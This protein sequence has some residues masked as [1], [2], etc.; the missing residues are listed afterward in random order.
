M[1]SER[2]RIADKGWGDLLVAAQLG[3]AGA[4]R[5][6]VASVTPFVSAVARQRCWSADMVP[7]VVQ[8]VMLSVHRVRHTYET[9][10]PVKP[11]L[12]AIAVR[13][14]IDAM[15]RR[16]HLQ[17]HEV[18]NQA[19]YDRYADPRH[20]HEDTRWAAHAFAR[21]TSGLTPRQKQALDLVKVRGM[22][23]SEAAG[24]SGQSVALLKVNIHR[25]MRKM[26]LEIAEERDRS[27][28]SAS[29]P[30]VPEQSSDAR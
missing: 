22:S 20:N 29:L 15:R 25:A 7:D 9:G 14:S 27:D 6:F 13:R 30:P 19:A 12:A 4:Y 11:W 18:H 2:A 21:V 1:T 26:R 8:D 16:G 28:G 3:D 5:R 10:R 24:A 23:L 17:A